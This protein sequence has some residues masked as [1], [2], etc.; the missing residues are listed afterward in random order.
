[1]IGTIFSIVFVLMG[2]SGLFDVFVAWVEDHALLSAHLYL[3]LALI[4]SAV[5]CAAFW[6]VTETIMRK[7]LN[8]E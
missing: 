3:G 7:K 2:M 8:L 5:I 1:V 6:L 4:V